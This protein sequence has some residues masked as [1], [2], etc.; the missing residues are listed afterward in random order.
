MTM[1]GS[2]WIGTYFDGG[3]NGDG[4]MAVW[5]RKFKL[6]YCERGSGE[7]CNVNV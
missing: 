6:G 7:I 1:E 3:C 4:S 2:I 5:G